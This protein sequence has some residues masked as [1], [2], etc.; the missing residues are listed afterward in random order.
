VGSTQAPLGLQAASVA[1]ASIQTTEVV[2][3]MDTRFPRMVVLGELCS[4]RAD[5]LFDHPKLGYVD[6]LVMHRGP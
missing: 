6:T 2:A 5:D 1:T 4:V 3:V